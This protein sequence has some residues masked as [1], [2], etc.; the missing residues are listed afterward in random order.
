MA[1]LVTKSGQ[2]TT[3]TPLE[4]KSG[5]EI[6]GFRVSE[7]ITERFKT[8]RTNTWTKQRVKR[9][10]GLRPQRVFRGNRQLS[11]TT[12]CRRPLQAGACVI[13]LFRSV[14][15]CVRGTADMRHQLSAT[16][17]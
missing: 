16:P 14:F 7:R 4:V 6:I 9:G 5:S 10:Q 17:A 1:P 8:G 15:Q 13:K 12:A 2:F 3:L 11:E